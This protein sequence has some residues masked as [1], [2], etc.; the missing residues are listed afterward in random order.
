MRLQ[1][2]IPDQVGMSPDR[3]QQV[4]AQARRWVEQGGTPTL[5]VLAARRGVIVL[6]EAFGV[7]R[8]GADAPPVPL[9]ALFPMA[10]LAK[11]ITATA[12]L[13]LV[14]EGRVGLNRPVQEY[15]P[16]YI[17]EGKDAVL[18]HHLLT[19]T[20]GWRGD[21]VAAHVAR[22]QGTVVIPRRSRPNTRSCRSS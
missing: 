1:S 7:L 16:E 9:D 12:I 8:P 4:R 11:I 13:I 17:G 3:I 22:K 19:H 14:E 20:S 18:V 6:H 10:S 2:G 5:V 21:D 15:L